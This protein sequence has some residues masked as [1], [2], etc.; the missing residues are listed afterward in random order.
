MKKLLIATAIFMGLCG[1]V[2][3]QEKVTATPAKK[4]TKTEVAKT[5]AKSLK[6]TPAVTTVPVTKA[7]GTPDMRL[8]VNKDAAKARKTGKTKADGTPDM[9]FKENKDKAKKSS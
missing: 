8:K 6:T 1:I 5:S 4:A 7:D 3:A 9:R 2:S